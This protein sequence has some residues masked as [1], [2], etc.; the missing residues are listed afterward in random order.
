MLAGLAVLAA[1]CATAPRPAVAPPAPPLPAWQIPPDAYGWQRLYRVAYSGPEGEGSLRVTLRLEA[2]ERYQVQAVDPL[3]RT[4]WSLEV[5]AGKGL[6][7]DHRGRVFCRLDGKIELAPLPLGPFPLVALPALL[8]GRLPAEPA[9]PPPAGEGGAS[10][11]ATLAPAPPPGPGSLEVVF[12]DAAGRRWSAQ[13]RQGQVER[14]TL[15][16]GEAPALWWMQS[17][18]WAILSDRGRGVQVRWREVLRERLGALAPLAP[19]AGF[20]EGPCRPPEPPLP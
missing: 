7:L 14:W 15:W 16:Q 12:R 18:G 1:G 3:G 8:L 4:L 11:A 19:P 13:V 6:W 17:G 9:P 2:P 20:R 5:N 10:V